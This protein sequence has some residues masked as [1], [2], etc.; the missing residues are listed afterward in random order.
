ML[1]LQIYSF[2]S[3]RNNLAEYFLPHPSQQILQIA[4]K[5][6]HQRKSSILHQKIFNTYWKN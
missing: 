4:A 6:F 5:E 2:F 3:Y 1:T